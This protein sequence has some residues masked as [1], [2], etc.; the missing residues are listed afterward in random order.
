MK[1]T[2]RPFWNKSIKRADQMACST[3]EFKILWSC[4]LFV[5]RSFVNAEI[6][7]IFPTSKSHLELF[8]LF[9]CFVYVWML[10]LN[11]VKT[12]C[13]VCILNLKLRVLFNL[14]VSKWLNLYCIHYFH[15]FDGDTL[16]INSVLQNTFLILINNQR[17]AAAETLFSRYKLNWSKC[18]VL[19]AFPSKSLF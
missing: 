18:R 1:W 10:M 19:A 9:L 2:W 17:K 4:H 6:I 14:T 15:N 12:P 7:Y 3:D 16:S 8:C 5:R 11:N 13:S